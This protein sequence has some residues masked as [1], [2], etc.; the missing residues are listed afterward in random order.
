MSSVL[1]N[2]LNLKKLGFSIIVVPYIVRRAIEDSIKISLQKKLYPNIDKKF[3]W[4]FS[5]LSNII[6]KLSDI[7]FKA[8]DSVVYP[9]HGV[10]KIIDI[11][12]QAI[13]GIEIQLYVIHFE[14]E[15]MSLRIPVRKAKKSGLTN[16][17][18]FYQ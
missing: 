7:N 3:I 6:V 17:F 9:S 2:N 14:R 18:K 10:G 1:N 15:K 12:S 5:K 4:N 8:G 11:E 16:I 13:G